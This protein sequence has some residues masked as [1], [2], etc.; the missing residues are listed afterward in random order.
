MLLYIIIIVLASLYIA[1][2]IYEKIMVNKLRSSFKYVIHVNGIRGKSTTTRLIDA[3]MRECGFKVFSKTTGT[4]PTYIDVAGN[5][6]EIFRLGK[7]NIREQIKMMKLALK[8]GAEVLVL[9][10]MAV[11]PELQRICEEKILKANICVITNIRLDHI[12]DMGDNLEEI[13][14]AFSNTIPTNGT[15]IINHSDFDK[16]FVIY[17]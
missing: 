8:E 2:V 1:Y 12:N 9:E 16:F 11:N 15:L 5:E 10:C 7:A 14:E 13:A 3:G 6:H 4:I 17:S